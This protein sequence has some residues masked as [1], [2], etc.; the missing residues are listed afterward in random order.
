[1][2]NGENIDVLAA[3]YALGTLDAAE[4]SLVAARRQRDLAL[5]LAIEQWEARLAPLA[6]T[7]S[8]VEPRSGLFSEIETRIAVR[9]AATVGNIQ[10]VVL[11]HSMRRWR[12]RALAAAALAACLLV[13]IGVRESMRPQA[14]TSYV[15]VF[16]KDDASP[17]FL[18]SVDLETR[19][20]SI[21][22]V[23]AQPQAGKTY[24]LWIAS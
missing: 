22:P 24:Q 14:P 2:T 9:H 10:V 17:A 18:L 12:R 5:D 7:I 21:R 11:E 19:M 16:Q 23:A 4:R 13:A 15:A 3:E 8:S 1:M 6:Q 20:L